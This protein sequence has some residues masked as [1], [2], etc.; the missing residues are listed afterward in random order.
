MACKSS[1]NVLHLS[2][3]P[4]GT[5]VRVTMQTSVLSAPSRR[6][7]HSSHRKN[8]R[9]Q[10]FKAAYAFLGLTPLELH[11]LPVQ[12]RYPI[13]LH[14]GK[15]ATENDKHIPDCLLVARRP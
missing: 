10:L 2:K 6:K 4:P 1:V 3:W 9:L 7:E 11:S 14:F 8:K 5:T 12:Y 13:Q 15:I